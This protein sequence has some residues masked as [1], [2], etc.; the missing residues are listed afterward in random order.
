[1]YDS[2]KDLA[3]KGEKSDPMTVVTVLKTTFLGQLIN[4]SF[5]P[6]ICDISF[7]PYILEDVLLHVGY[8][9][10]STLNILGQTPFFTLCHFSVVDCI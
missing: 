6:V 7:N 10:H 1:M 3:G 9:F 4:D 8:S 2:V 5:L